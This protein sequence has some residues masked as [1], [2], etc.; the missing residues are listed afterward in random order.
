MLVLI[1]PTH[2]WMEG[3]VNPQPGWVGSRFWTWELSHDSLLLYQLSYL[4]RLCCATLWQG[5]LHKVAAPY[6]Y[7]MY[8]VQ[9]YKD[10]WETCICWAVGPAL[11]SNSSNCLELI[12]HRQLGNL[13]YANRITLYLQNYG[14]LTELYYISQMTLNYVNRVMV[15]LP[16][17]MSINRTI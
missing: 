16:T 17:F 1:L 8:I 13:C 10:D 12:S 11:R 15:S 9:L 7:F 5:S 2:K 6:F 14:A 4:S 3:W